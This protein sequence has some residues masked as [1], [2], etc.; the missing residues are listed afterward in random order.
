MPKGIPRKHHPDLYADAVVHTAEVVDA[1]RL[2]PAQAT[3]RKLLAQV[4][5]QYHSLQIVD[6]MFDDHAVKQSLTNGIQKLRQA[7]AL[8]QQMNGHASSNGHQRALPEATISARTNHP[9]RRYVRKTRPATAIAPK[10]KRVATGEKTR[11]FEERSKTRVTGPRLSLFLLDH[12]GDSD[13]QGLD[14]MYETLKAKTG[15][16]FPN[17]KTGLNAIV[18]G[19]LLRNGLIKKAADGSGYRRLVAGRHMAATLRKTLI[20]TGQMDPHSYFL[21][22]DFVPKSVKRD[23]QHMKVG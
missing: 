21:P 2:N 11:S 19:R 20:S 22:Q 13:Y 18:G 6:R 8:R 12:F 5:V 10:P 17:G 23:D 16:T 1:A 9:T 7:G 14:V 3:L 15:T 4:E